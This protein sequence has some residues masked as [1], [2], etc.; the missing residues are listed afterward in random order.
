MNDA[1]GKAADTGAHESVGIGLGAAPTIS[2]MICHVAFI[3]R[4]RGR[5]DDKATAA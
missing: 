3:A 1:V 4:L 5:Y 2:E